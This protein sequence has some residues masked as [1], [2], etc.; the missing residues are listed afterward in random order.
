MYEIYKT[1]R[2][3]DGAVYY[4]QHLLRSGCNS[5]PAYM[6]SGIYILSSLAKHGKV[7]HSKEVLALVPT[8]E[9]ADFYEKYV[10]SFARASGENIMNISNGGEGRTGPHS[11]ETIRK[12][13]GKKRTIEVRR[14]LSEQKMGHV[15]P[16]SQ[17]QKRAYANSKPVRC[18]ELG[19]VFPSQLEAGLWVLKERGWFGDVNKVLKGEQRTCGGFTW[20]PAEKKDISLFPAPSGLSPIPKKSGLIDYHE[21]HREN[22]EINTGTRF[23]VFR[24]SSP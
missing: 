21:I 2:I 9:L 17:V 5:N 20:E 24:C 12:L 4:G 19:Y 22:P 3:H 13:T 11:E 23:G 6:G 7:A 18:V 1:T 8:K 14:R 16:A 15:Q 10:I